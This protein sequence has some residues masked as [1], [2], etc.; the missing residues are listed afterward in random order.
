MPLFGESAF[1]LDHCS[2]AVTHPSLGEAGPTR[3]PAL[4][5]GGRGWDLPE[6]ACPPGKPPRGRRSRRLHDLENPL[7]HVRGRPG[8][9]DSLRQLAGEIM[10]TA[11]DL[12][13]AS[14]IGSV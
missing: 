3:V 9:D 1:W 2:H 5:S 12:C 14:A 7:R 10:S 11:S 13:K 6:A 8:A 4:L